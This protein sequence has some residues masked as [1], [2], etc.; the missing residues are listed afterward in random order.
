MVA[1]E[2]AKETQII[3]FDEFFVEDIADAMILGSIFRELFSLGVVLVATSNIVPER[4]YSRGL[5]RELFLPAINMLLEN[6]EVLNLDSGVDYRFLLETSYTNYLFPYNEQ[7]RKKFFDRFLVRNKDFSKDYPL[8]ILGRNMPARLHSNLDVCFDFSVIC[9]AGRSAYDYI[10]ICK[11]YDH[12]YIYNLRGFDGYNEDVARR[13]IALIDECYDQ[14]KKV[15]MLANEDFKNIYKG[16]K[17]VFEFQR[18]ISRINDMQN[19]NF[20]H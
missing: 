10:E 9:G 16:E 13:F 3:C 19:P 4:L 14:S 15:V 2:I 8:Q 7:N 18:T 6:T 17:L 1:L 20:A 5:R 12:I 11:N